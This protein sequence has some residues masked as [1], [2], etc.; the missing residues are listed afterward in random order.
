MSNAIEAKEYAVGKFE[1]LLGD[2]V[3]FVLI[4]NTVSDLPISNEHSLKYDYYHP[5]TVASGEVI[6]K[7]E[8]DYDKKSKE[9]CLIGKIFGCEELK[10]DSIE[11]RI[12]ELAFAEELADSIKRYD[13]HLSTDFYINGIETIKKE[14]IKL[15]QKKHLMLHNVSLFDSSAKHTYGIFRG[16]R[17]QILGIALFPRYKYTK[18]NG[19]DVVLKG[20]YYPGGDFEQCKTVEIFDSEQPNFAGIRFEDVVLEKLNEKGMFYAIK[21]QR[22]YGKQHRGNYQKELPKEHESINSI[23]QTIPKRSIYEN[24]DEYVTNAFLEKT[25]ELIPRTKAEDRPR[26]RLRK[27]QL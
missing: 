26:R 8:F 2:G 4:P 22:P 11:V 16:D 23:F 1:N 3:D 14:F 17:E 10:D 9:I 12:K 7:P 20:V 21:I 13:D 6:I 24:I 18:K 5:P 19:S 27:I 15:C 25:Y